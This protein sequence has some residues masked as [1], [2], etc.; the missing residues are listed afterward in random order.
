MN[1]KTRAYYSN[2]EKRK[3]DN[4]G[5]DRQGQITLFWSVNLSNLKIEGL[6]CFMVRVKNITCL[7]VLHDF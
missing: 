6:E 3:G 4:F 2:L 7:E 1:K 5:L